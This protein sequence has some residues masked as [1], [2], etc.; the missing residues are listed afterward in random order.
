MD[1]YISGLNLIDLVSLKHKK[2]RREV[3]ELWMK[4]NG[5]EITDTEAHMLGMLEIKNMTMAESARMMNISRQAVHKCAKKLIDEGYIKMTSIEGNKRDK[6]I[7][8][9]EKGEEYCNEMIK[10]KERIEE[11]ISKNIGRKNVEM[12]KRYLREDWIES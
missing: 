7:S 5:N 8:L 9:T 4:N 11:H 6:L 12:L 1:D 2:L 10:L 3:M